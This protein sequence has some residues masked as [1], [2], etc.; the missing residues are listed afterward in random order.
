MRWS[1]AELGAAIGAE[2]VWAGP[3]EPERW[4]DGAGID[5]R[6][7]VRGSLFVA[8]RA[9]RDGHDFAAAAAAG[10]AGAVLVDH[11]MDLP[12]P[13]LVVE[14]T[15]AGLG[16]AG[17]AARARLEGPVVGI[18]GSVGKTTTKDLLAAVFAG[19]GPTAASERSLN[20]ELGVPLTLLGAPAGARRAVLEMGARGPGHIA[21]LCD[22]GRPQVGI[23]T[24]V[25][26]VHTET[27]GTVA[28]IGRA[29]G[30]L[31]EALPAD[32][33]A[34][35]TRAYPEVA[36]MAS[37]SSA[38]VVWFG[39]GGDVVATDVRLGDDLVPTFRFS[40]PWGSAEVRLGL[41]G[42]HNVA[43]ALAA[44]AA[45]LGTGL[46]LEDVVA[47][48]ERATSSPWRMDLRVSSAGGRVLDDSYNAS[49]TSMRAALAMLAELPAR[50]R[51]AVLGLMAELGPGAAAEHVRIAEEARS[52]GIEVVTV[53]TELYGQRPLVDVD[54][55]IAEL[56]PPAEGEAVLVKGS[57][58]A[59]LE[60]LAAAWTGRP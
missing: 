55:A 19:V 42:A 15:L 44:A 13:Q 7:L 17:Q 29:K 39:E 57:R 53:G 36:D 35:L 52:L 20:N 23:V 49:P 45:A 28:E 33:L 8:V 10:G 32:G 58:V 51:V 5:S 41:R 26:A 22:L 59:G 12:V 30:E 9:E 48:L 60:R 56:A 16:R 3:P 43:N 46:S 40:S 2:V 54:T 1:V 24:A 50:R 14:D 34:V 38:P 25:A 47:G 11:G 21:L 27:F 37:R 6:R 31:I 18:T 4:V